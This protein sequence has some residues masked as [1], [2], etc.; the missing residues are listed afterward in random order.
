MWMENF[1]WDAK[2]PD[3][4]LNTTPDSAFPHH[5]HALL[6]VLC[7]L[8]KQSKVDKKGHKEEKG[9]SKLSEEQSSCPTHC[10]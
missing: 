5:E 1:T 2:M 4:T 8:I 10:H 3:T 9:K 6:G 7:P